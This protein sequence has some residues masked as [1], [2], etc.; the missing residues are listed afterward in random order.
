MSVFFDTNILIYAQ[1]SGDKAVR[2]RAL[3]AHGGIVSV[4][5][6]NKFA[7]VAHRK[8]GKT[9]DEVDEAIEDVLALVEPPPPLTFATNKDARALAR[10]HNFAFCDALIVAAAIEAG[11]DRLYSEV[12]QHGRNIAGLTIIDPFAI[13]P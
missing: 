2:A 8:L 13:I 1:Q 7:A 6:L 11:Y 10:A 12:M 3:L 9:W 4:Q 5:A